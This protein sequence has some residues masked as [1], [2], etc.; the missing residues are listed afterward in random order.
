MIPGKFEYH[1]P[2]D[3]GEA[4]AMLRRYDDE[5]KLLAGGQSLIP[6]MRFRLAQPEHLIDISRLPGLSH[7][8]ERN[9]HLA[10]GALTTEA[11]LE[12]SELVRDHYPIL[13]DATRVIADPLVRNL[14]TVGGNVAHADP[15]NDHPAVMIALRAE[16]VATG[17]DGE[18]TIP[19][20]DFFVDTFTTSLRPDEVLTEIRVPH[21]RSGGRGAYTKLERKVGDF[22]IAAVAAQ[23][24]IREGTIVEAGVAFTNVG[25]SPVRAVAT[26]AALVGKPATP[27]TFAAAAEVAAGECDP[28]S[29]LRGPADYKRSVVRTLT[30]RTLAKAA[31][32]AG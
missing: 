16:M 31:E 11:A 19:V 5:A 14:A 15:A 26:E 21:H 32:R 25:P 6:L 8:E 29:D 9:G 12:A 1:V 24:T 18:R 4:V 27:A 3:V 2:A 23:L 17:P 28:A 13:H 7:V 30:E 20:D 22:A 10:I